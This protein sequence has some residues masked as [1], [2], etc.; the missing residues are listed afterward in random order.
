MSMILS[1]FTVYVIVVV[2]AVHMKTVLNRPPVL[3]EAH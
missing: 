1:V 2:F 3:Y